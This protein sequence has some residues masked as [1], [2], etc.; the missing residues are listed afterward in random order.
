MRQGKIPWYTH[1]LMHR[2][3]VTSELH[4][5]YFRLMT[6][7]YASP[8]TPEVLAMK[9]DIV[10]PIVWPIELLYNSVRTGC[11]WVGVQT[12]WRQN[13]VGKA[14]TQQKGPSGHP[15]EFGDQLVRRCWDEK[16]PREAGPPGPR[17]RTPGERERHTAMFGEAGEVNM[18]Q[19]L[20]SLQLPLTHPT[21]QI[22]LV[23]YF[24]KEVFTRFYS[25]HQYVFSK[26]LYMSIKQDYAIIYTPTEILNL[27]I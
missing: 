5:S 17:L 19:S 2:R 16:C 25:L 8:K 1:R 21:F 11:R 10:W 7:K 9:I 26:N 15:I 23:V 12:S 14:T 18:W 20:F 22:K 3:R 27:S 6:I 13:V 24:F 4:D